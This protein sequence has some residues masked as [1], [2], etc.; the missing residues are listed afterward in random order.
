MGREIWVIGEELNY[1]EIGLKQ[2]WADIRD[3][4]VDPKQSPAFDGYTALACTGRALKMRLLGVGQKNYVVT[5]GGGARGGAVKANLGH[6]WM[7]RWGDR[8]TWDLIVGKGIAMPP[9]TLQPGRMQ[10]VSGS[11]VTEV[12][13]PYVE[14]RVRDLILADPSRLAVCPDDMPCTRAETVSAGSTLMLP[15]P[16]G[17]SGGVVLR[18]PDGHHTPPDL[19]MSLPDPPAVPILYTLTE[20][21]AKGMLR[22]SGS[23]ASKAA[24][25]AEKRGYPPGDFPVPAEKGRRGVPGRWRGSDLTRWQTEQ[26]RKGV[27]DD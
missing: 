18:G 4:E 23:A 14:E 15:A 25:R 11:E 13:I 1:G 8:S 6:K 12:Q 2:H 3:P 24:Q 26:D 9:I 21:R 22:L 10:Y 16:P 19:G 20:A 7:A 27:P 17:V 5:M